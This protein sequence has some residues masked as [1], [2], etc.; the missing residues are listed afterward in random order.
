SR[1]IHA[2]RSIRCAEARPFGSAKKHTS[3]SSSPAISTTRSPIP[4]SLLAAR[5][6]RWAP[7]RCPHAFAPRGRAS[8]SSP[9]R[10]SKWFRR[11]SPL[12]ATAWKFSGITIPLFFRPERQS[13]PG[14]CSCDRP[15]VR[16]LPQEVTYAELDPRF[17]G[18]RHHRGGA[19]LRRDRGVSRWHRQNS[20]LHIPRSLCHL[21]CN[22]RDAARRLNGTEGWMDGGPADVSRAAFMSVIPYCSDHP[23][24]LHRR[25]PRE[26]AVS[27]WQVRWHRMIPAA[28][29]P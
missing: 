23:E 11:L 27:R 26:L 19:G 18:H 14:R 9:S 29:H 25:K 4:S 2:S 15:V 8:A 22:G 24:R 6:C 13:E 17:P 10:M 12:T 16:V 20:L 3:T 21:R 28:C 1:D 5:W 7:A